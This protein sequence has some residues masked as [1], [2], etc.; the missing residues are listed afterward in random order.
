MTPVHIRQDAFAIKMA[1]DT[2]D[3]EA[4]TVANDIAE[5]IDQLEELKQRNMRIDKKVKLAVC[6]EGIVCRAQA[7][8]TSTL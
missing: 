8:T 7:A 4:T 6:N 1:A 3:C 5:E 2:N